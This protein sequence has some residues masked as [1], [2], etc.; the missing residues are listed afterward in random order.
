MSLKSRHEVAAKVEWEGGLVAALELG[1]RADDMP[2][3]D[4][5]L[6]EAW[7]RMRMA[8]ELAVVL[9]SDVERMLGRL[10]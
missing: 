5:E 9:G 10:N 3:G 8:W 6:R 7:K 1:L 2:E 4:M